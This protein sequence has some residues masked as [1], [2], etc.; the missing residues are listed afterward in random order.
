MAMAFSEWLSCG[1]PVVATDRGTYPEIMKNGYN[2]TICN[3]ENLY[4]KVIEAIEK[5]FSNKK[6]LEQM[7][8]NARTYTVT[9]L[10]REKCLQNYKHFFN[11]RYLEIDNLLSAP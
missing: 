3:T 4:I 7:G 5:F 6:L 11:E 1:L 10:S 8:S 9:R 2:G